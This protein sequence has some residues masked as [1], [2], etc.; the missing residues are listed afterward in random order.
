MARKVG[1]DEATA[2]AIAALDEH[3]D[4]RGYPAGVAG[5]Q[6]PL[7]GRIL[8]IAQTAEVFW[9]LGGVGAVCEVARARP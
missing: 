6:I 2:A 5:E 9:Q 1:M 7:L 3:W 4:G 8:C